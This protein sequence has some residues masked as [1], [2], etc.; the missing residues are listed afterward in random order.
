MRKVIFADGCFYHIYNRGVDK[1]KIFLDDADRYRFIHSLYEF[2]NTEPARH[3]VRRV[4]NQNHGRGSTSTIRKTR[5]RLVNII[6]FCMI[7]NHFH[8]ILL[9]KLKDGVV[10]FMQKFGTGYTA[11]FNK[12]RQ[13]NGVLFQGRF[14]A[15]LIDRDVYLIY[16]SR[17]IHLNPLK[18]I[19]PN[20]KENGIK[21]LERARKFLES[22][23][24][25]SY[26]DHIDKRNFPSVIEPAAI[27][28]YFRNTQ[29]YQKFIYEYLPKDQ[30]SIK[31]YI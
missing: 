8:L 20:W 6:C 15:K 14:Q 12:R 28:S 11:Y 13:R 29:A 9:Q 2:N 27:K 10:K 4:Q 17:Y 19:E 18:L 16:L 7:P 26:L 5:R 3:T 22:Y 31:D 1:R 30:S 21:D 24:W 23:R 25:S